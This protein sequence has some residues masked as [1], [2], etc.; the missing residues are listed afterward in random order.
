MKS[1][2]FKRIVL[3][4]SPRLFRLSCNLL[5]NREEAEDIVQEVFLKLWGMRN[6]LGA[7]RS[8]EALAVSITRNLS[9]DHLRR[10]KRE[11]E[12]Q[13]AID[14]ALINDQNVLNDI[15]LA[16]QHEEL[17]RIINE[18]SEPQRSI[19]QLR[20]VEGCSYEEISKLL[21]MNVNAIRVSISRAR[22]QIR[23]MMVNHYS[24]WKA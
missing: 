4:L 13:K 23:K 19:V 15:I 8:I 21:N 16:E 24:T 5:N 2:E 22:T 17:L 18:L 7:Y 11:R 3:P 6:Q 9:I 1:S 14:P 10:Y 12:K 20:H